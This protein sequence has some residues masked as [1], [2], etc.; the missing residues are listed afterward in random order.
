MILKAFFMLRV[1]SACLLF[2]L[3][4]SIST[5]F[6]ASLPS[7]TLNALKAAG[8]RPENVA[9]VVRSVDGGA[10]GVEHNVDKP[11]NP[12]S[13]MKL[14]TTY[15][16]LELLGPAFTWKTE[17]F[18]DADPVAGTLRGNLYLKGSGDPRFAQEQLWSLLRQLRV[19]GIEK[20][21]G[22]IVLDRSAF[23]LP[24]FDPAAFD[25]DPYRPYNVGPDALL[26]NLNSIRLTLHPNSDNNAVTLL[27]ETPLEGVRFD[28]RLRLTNSA[29]GDWREAITVSVDGEGVTLR[30]DYS[31]ACGDKS[32]NIAPW[33]SM[34]Y[35]SYLLPAIWHELGGGW[36]G[37]LVD[38]RT[39]SNARLIVAQDSPPLMD[40]VRE[41]NKY[42][43]NVMAR[44]LF[45]T[46]SSARPAAY[47]GAEERVRSWL[48]NKGVNATGFVL[49]NGCGLS[50]TERLTA[51]GM[52]SLLS[53]AWQSSVMSELMSS[54]PIA[55]VDGTL[56]KR[57][58]Q[59]ASTGQA[60]LKTGYLKGVRALA[61]YVL[62]AQKRR[63]IVVF[64]VNDPNA[65][66]AKPAMDGLLDW[67]ASGAMSS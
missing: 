60:H 2:F 55:G 34:N 66:A 4:S 20:I 17:A 32:F 27:V 50:R 41:I 31:L 52:A 8:I 58:Q 25:G 45:L 51:G 64:F 37:R 12:A 19:R 29:C 9:V 35:V 39:P 44:Q 42:S 3:F 46:L 49:D 67:V 30:G 61:G 18:S 26:V 10:I 21:E 62:D 33:S 59:G 48:K 6:A 23:L 36:K 5:V 16:G 53:S 56:K 14:V 38:G 40:V 15:A 22:D 7:F 13:T 57:M 1:V 54:L 43:N 47:A 65:L 63:W 28:N 11:M 24:P